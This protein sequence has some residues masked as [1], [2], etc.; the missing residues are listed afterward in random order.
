MVFAGEPA[1]R[2]KEIYEVVLQAH[3][4][5]VAAMKPGVRCHSVDRVARRC[6]ARAG[7]GKAFRHG[8]G[9][10]IGLAVHERPGLG[11]RGPGGRGIPLRS[12]MV[13]TVEPGVYLEGLGG[14]RIEDD[15]LL[16]PRGSER[17]SSLPRELDAMILR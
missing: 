3:D 2:M 15:V 5:A 12:G 1:A 17:L 4:A 16:V 13:I 11:S 8:L 7:Y 10:G 6:I 9:H 14:V